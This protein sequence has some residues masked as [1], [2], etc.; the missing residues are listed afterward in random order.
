M[1]HESQTRTQ[2]RIPSDLAIDEGI[3]GC[4]EEESVVSLDR[5]VALLPEFTW[6]QI[7]HTV[8]RLA[9][10]GRI[11]LRRHGSDYTVFSLHYAA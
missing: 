2:Y 3:L 6:N 1:S 10:N 8:D 7:F 9:R 11:A 5:L 4:L